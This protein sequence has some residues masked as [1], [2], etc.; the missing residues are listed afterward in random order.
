MIYTVTM[1]PALD[2]RV[3]TE[4]LYH[5]L[6]NRSE[7]EE[8]HVGGKGINVAVVL[9]SFGVPATAMGFIGGLTGEMLRR[10][11]EQEKIEGDFL[12]VRGLT[13]INVKIREKEAETD[14]NGAGPDVSLKDLKR[15]AEKL[16]QIPDGSVVV[17]SGSIPATLPKDSYECL[18][19]AL[20]GR[21][22]RIVADMAGAQLNQII[23]YRPWL[24]KPNREELGEI[25]GEEVKDPLQALTLAEKLLTKGA[26]NV[27]VSLGEDGAIFVSESGERVAT[28]SYFGNV[29]DT[30]GSGDALLAAF[31]AGKESGA[32]NS[33][34][35]ALGVAAGCATA[36]RSGLA[37]AAETRLLMEN[38]IRRAPVIDL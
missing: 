6:I 33:Q 9:K 19:D 8:I 29:K 4:C 16:M 20:C 37:T 1:N 2:Y 13:R 10:A 12:R 32:N 11:L 15:L 17:L 31:L 38:G 3:Y 26:A 7:R 24:M 14:I 23:K 22:V 34:A 5:G 18:F 21:D 30:V 36:F 28:P 27:I 35:L 25:F